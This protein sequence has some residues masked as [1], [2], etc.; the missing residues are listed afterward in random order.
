MSGKAGNE[1]VYIPSSCKLAWSHVT[2]QRG[3]R[4]KLRVFQ[5]SALQIRRT[6]HLLCFLNVVITYI[7]A[8]NRPTGGAYAPSV[9]IG[10]DDSCIY[11]E[12]GPVPRPASV[13]YHVD[14][15][16]QSYLYHRYHV[17]AFLFLTI[18]HLFGK[19]GQKLNMETAP[20]TGG[21]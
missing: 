9:P 2:R 11:D 18:P 15:R 13:D 7:S 16:Y 21:P 5:G 6:K 3:E 19:W 8:S 14:A 12:K 1:E 17:E 4:I 10:R 20:K